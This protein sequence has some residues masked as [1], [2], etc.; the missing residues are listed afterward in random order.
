MRGS[1]PRARGTPPPAPC[2]R[3]GRRFIPAGAGNT[4]RSRPPAGAAPVHP[5]GRGEHWN[6]SAKASEPY[7]SSPRARGTHRPQRT[8]P[9][10]PRFIPAGAG[11]TRPAGTARPAVPVHP[12]GRGEHFALVHLHPLTGGSSPRARGTPDDGRS[13]QADHRFI[14]AGAGNTMEYI[15]EIDSDAVHP[16]GRGEHDVMLV[17]TEELDGSSPRARG[18]RNRGGP[19][20]EGLRFIPAGAGNTSR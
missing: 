17:T 6:M 13:L 18:T 5:R 12:R 8:R 4:P 20:N 10:S 1:S 2:R 16:R 9:A 15:D 19:R 11:N 14:P 7:G 3:Y